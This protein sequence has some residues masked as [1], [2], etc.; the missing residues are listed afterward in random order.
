MWND[1]PARRP[2][3]GEIDRLEEM[4]VS[5]SVPELRSLLSVTGEPHVAKLFSGQYTLEPWLR[6]RLDADGDWYIG[7]GIEVMPDEDDGA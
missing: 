7:W 5:L 4:D 2:I 1:R 3:V 6:A